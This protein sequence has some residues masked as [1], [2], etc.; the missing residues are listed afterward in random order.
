MTECGLAFRNP[1]RR[2]HQPSHFDVDIFA[3]YSCTGDGRGFRFDLS[4]AGRHVGGGFAEAFKRF[5]AA[6]QLHR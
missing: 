4:N 2:S 5:Y 1:C 6:F 3:A